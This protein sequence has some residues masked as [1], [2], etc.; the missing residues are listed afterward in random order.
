MSDPGSLDDILLVE[1]N[2]G[3][4]RLTVEI[5]RELGWNSTVH[6]TTDGDEALDF[7]HRRGEYTDAPRSELILL[8]WH[9]PRTTGR[10]ILAELEGNRAL[11]NVPLVVL[12]GSGAAIE[13]LEREHPQADASLTKPLN[14][15]DL[16]TTL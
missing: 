10:K 2:P 13:R 8:D 4:A 7:L 9:L 12:S 6:I 3:D 16:V 14:P 11:E 1:D 5:L 15:D